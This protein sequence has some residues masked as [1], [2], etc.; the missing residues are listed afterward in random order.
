MGQAESAWRTLEIRFSLSEGMQYPLSCIVH[1]PLLYTGCKLSVYRTLGMAQKIATVAVDLIFI[2]VFTSGFSWPLAPHETVHKTLGQHA[3]NHNKSLGFLS[4]FCFLFVCLFSFFIFY[5]SRKRVILGWHSC[6]QQQY[7]CSS[8]W[9]VTLAGQ[10]SRLHWPA[11]RCLLC[12]C[13]K[14]TPP[15][16]RAEG[17]SH[18]QNWEGNCSRDLSALPLLAELVT[19]TVKS[20]RNSWCFQ[21]HFCIVH[22]H[23]S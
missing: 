22:E 6:L 3:I 23:L 19:G 21:V 11:L 14:G 10:R 8:S 2:L 16:D 5:F 17:Q 18:W 7:S 20:M 1:F 12:Q 15:L 13:T 9:S 4:N